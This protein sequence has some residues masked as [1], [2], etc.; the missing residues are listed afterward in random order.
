MAKKGS[1]AGQRGKVIG[2]AGVKWKIKWDKANGKPNP[3]TYRGVNLKVVEGGGGA[4]KKKAKPAP[5]PVSE[6]ESESESEEEK[7]CQKEKGS[8]KEKT[9]REIQGAPCRAT[10]CIFERGIFGGIFGLVTV[11]H[12]HHILKIKKIYSVS[13]VV[14]LYHF[15]SIHI[16]Q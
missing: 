13:I 1:R 16:L 11:E 14:L 4:S 12:I 5:K 10:S 9:R 6:S 3:G 7:E 8:S 15:T 2:R